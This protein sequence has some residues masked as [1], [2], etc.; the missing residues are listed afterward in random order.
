MIV[1][2]S[3]YFIFLFEA[4]LCDLKLI[5]FNNNNGYLTFK[6]K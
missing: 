1:Y 2:V 5:L 4:E 6:M 3:I